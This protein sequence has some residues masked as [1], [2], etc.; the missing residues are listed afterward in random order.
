MYGN[1]VAVSDTRSLYCD[2]SQ[3]SVLGPVL[4][5]MYMMSFGDIMLH[6]VLQ[7]MII[8]TSNCISHVMG[9]WY[10]QAGMRNVWITISSMLMI[11]RN[12]YIYML[13]INGSG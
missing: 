8:H 10:L 5:C 13:V 11:L 6:H 9:F 7:Y 2:I 12:L 1:P 3:A 4:L